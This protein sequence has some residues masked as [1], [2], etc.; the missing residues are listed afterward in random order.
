[1]WSNRVLR[2]AEIEDLLTLREKLVLET[3]SDKVFVTELEFGSTVTLLKTNSASTKT[4]PWL[5]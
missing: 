2:A 3:A 4:D 1:M 5:Q